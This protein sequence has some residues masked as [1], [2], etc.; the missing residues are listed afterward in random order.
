[1]ISLLPPLM[2]ASALSRALPLY[3]ARQNAPAPQ[4]SNSRCCAPTPHGQPYQ[5]C[6]EERMHPGQG[7]EVCP[8]AQKLWCRTRW[9]CCGIYHR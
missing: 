6:C 1:M 7:D 4:N 2:F 9:R 8:Q 5:H 3:I